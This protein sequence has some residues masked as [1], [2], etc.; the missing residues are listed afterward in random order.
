ML[1]QVVQPGDD[2]LQYLGCGDQ[3]YGVA[4]IAGKSSVALTA[5]CFGFDFHELTLL[6]EVRQ[7]AVLHVLDSREDPL[8]NHIVNRPR[9]AVLEFAPAHGLTHS[10]LGENLFQLLATQILKFL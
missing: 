7:A 6:V 1:I 8:G 2:L 10:G 4:H 9:V 5:V 3:E